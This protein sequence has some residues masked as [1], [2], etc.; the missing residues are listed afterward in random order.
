VR[1]V[2]EILPLCFVRWFSTTF[3]ERFTI[4]H[5]TCTNPR[6]GLFICT[7]ECDQN[8]PS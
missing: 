2:A 4:G 7:P 3:C 6:P 8:H 1:L 5:H